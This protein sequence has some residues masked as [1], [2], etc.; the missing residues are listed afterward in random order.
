MNKKKF[1]KI[2]EENQRKIIVKN[3]PL[4]SRFKEGDFFT[5][6][7]RQEISKDL[8]SVHFQFGFEGK[9]QLYFS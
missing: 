5:S 4:T 7:D 2:E 9:I 3:Q 8:K 6:S 1:L